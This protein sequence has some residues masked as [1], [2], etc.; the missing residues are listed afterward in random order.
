[1]LAIVGPTASGKSGIAVRMAKEI[2]GTVVNGDPF[3]A[4]KDIPIG[5]GQP[6]LDEQQGVPHV[7]YGVLPLNYTLNPASFGELV[8]EWLGAAQKAGSPPILV[9]GS[10][11]YLRGI[12]DQIDPLP[13]V[14]E[15]I[16]QRVRR[17]SHELGPPTLHRYL[18]AIDPSRAA[19]LHPNDGS[20]I[21][22]VLAL[23]L[24]T[25]K[26]PSDFLTNPSHAVPQGW[27]VILV[28]PQR[29]EMR[30]RIAQ[31]VKNMIDAGW[32]HE[33][34]EIENA[35]Q[36]HHLRRLRPLGYETWLDHPDPATA[37]QKITQ[38]TQAYAKRQVTWFRNQ[39]GDLERWEG[40]EGECKNN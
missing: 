7:G 32:Q 5:T 13:D 15:E 1:M 38:A 2:G 6:R 20:R 31:R 23:H 3:Q 9:T 39:M 18:Q 21:Q 19:D 24:A 33:V 37:Q 17:L 14:P 35:G 40:E 22:R 25:G 27:Q 16:V 36:A 11:L 8:R 30:Q 26:R 28:L 29:E 10:G 34:Q 4:F 12:W